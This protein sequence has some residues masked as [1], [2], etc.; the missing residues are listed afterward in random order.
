MGAEFLWGR[1]EDKNGASGDDSRVQF[2]FKYSF[3]SSDFFH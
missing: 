3:N 2:S 1:R